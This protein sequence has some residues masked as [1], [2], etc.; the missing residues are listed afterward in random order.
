MYLRDGSTPTVARVSTVRQKL[1]S[2]SQRRICSDSCTCCHCSTVRQ[3]LQSVSQR[4]IYSDSCA[5]CQYERE[6]AEVYLRDGGSTPTVVR[7]STVRQK[8]QSV[9]QRRMYSDSCTCCH[10]ETEVAECISE[11]DLLRQLHVFPL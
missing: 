6:V 2:I 1:Q 10:C 5:C 11:T 8:L 3:K 7:V 4:R 9:S